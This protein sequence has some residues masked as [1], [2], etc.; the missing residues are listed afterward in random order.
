[1]NRVSL[2]T[3]GCK[4]NYAETS[5]IAREFISRKYDIVDFGD[6]ADVT[7]IN[8]C[9][10]T[11]QADKKCRNAIRRAKR[12]NPDAFVVVSGC[13]AQL[14]P[15][16]IAAI[17]GVD[18]VLGNNEK[19]KLFELLGDFER[20]QKTQIHVSC[21][22]D[23]QLYNPAF[24]SGDRTRAFLKVQDGCDYTCSFCTIPLA[25]GKSRSRPLGDTLQHAKE[26]ANLGYKEIVLSGINL[27]LYGLDSN[28]NL[29]ELLKGLDQIEQVE[30]FRISSIEPNL[31]SEDIIRFVSESRA[32]QPHFHI[33]LQSGDDSV[34][35]KMRRRYKTDLYRSRIEFI[36]EI[37]PNA[38][39]GI[40]VIVG[41]PA[42]GDK[43]FLASKNFL[44]SL[45]I[46]YLHVFTYSERKN[47]KAAQ[48]TAIS[49]FSAIP[50]Q[51]RHRRS[52]ILRELSKKLQRRFYLKHLDTE[53]KVL[54]EKS[55]KGDKMS[56]FTDNYIK[57]SGPYDK[58]KAETISLEELASINAEGEVEITSSLEELSFSLPLL[59]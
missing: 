4:L 34:L 28:S 53:R 13:Y 39:I 30:R 21:I 36:Q 7:I 14:E 50:M 32:F 43:E 1:M 18:A 55:R 6:P 46:S 26:V 42:E 16:Q 25:R 24:S 23:T 31:L 29:L 19:F 3:L 37:I 8:T 54:W 22:D 10:V 20:A 38:A 35:G 2:H 9:T 47:T 27:G 58:T 52:A 51:E 56:G 48:Q 49:E 15:K 57:V 41:F 33:P 45:D 44:E 12:A 59:V 5:T 11:D 40:D 17:D